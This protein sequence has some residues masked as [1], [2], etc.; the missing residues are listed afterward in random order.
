MAN[1]DL[2]VA[3]DDR[4]L[5][6]PRRSSIRW[7]VLAAVILLIVAAGVGYFLWQQRPEPPIAAPVPAAPTAPT[8][9]A[10][11]SSEPRIERP[12][13]PPS[14]TPAVPLPA[15]AESDSALRDALALLFGAAR[16]DALVRLQDIIRNVVVTIDNLPRGNVALRL[17]PIKPVPGTFRVVGREG[18]VVVGLDNAARYTPYVQAMQAV[19]SAKLVA[20]YVRFYP[21][22]QQA[23]AELG[24]P[25]RYFNDRL[26]EVIDH[27]LAT[28][29]VSGPIAL[30]QPKVMYEY[31]DPALQ[32]L[33]AGQK[34]LI[35]M[36][37]ENEARV[38]A[39]LREIKRALS[40]GV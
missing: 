36:G 35:R 40:R 13:E 38:K 16:L 2:E 39:K 23:Y 27:L 8:P 29:E 11:A 18:T 22:F 37:P 15:L 12:I 32:D 30:V 20:I 26:F 4:P 17:S 7:G 3:P 33:S 10:Q 24:Y 9:P 1:L 5:L 19:D 34:I 6:A 14:A 25:S 21:L 28:P 31:A